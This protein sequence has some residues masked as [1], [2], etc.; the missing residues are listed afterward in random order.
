VVLSLQDVSPIRSEIESELLAIRARRRRQ[1]AEATYSDKLTEVKKI[2]ERL[3]CGTEPSGSSDPLVLPPLSVF[4]A[5]PSVRALKGSP[6]PNVLP[7][8][9]TSV[10]SDLK[11][12]LAMSLIRSDIHAW[13]VPAQKHLMTLLGYPNGW[14]SA[15]MRALPPVKRITARFF[16]RRCG[17]GKVGRGYQR[18]LCLD[19]K[20]VCSHVCVARGKSIG[21]EAP[22]E[23]EANTG[24]GNEQESGRKKK[25][26][27]KTLDWKIDLF[28]K[29]EKVSL[30]PIS[31][32]RC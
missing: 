29:D 17:E 20:G 27:V 28:E 5:L 14:Q 12:S 15:N 6:D 24:D 26:G 25:S 2:Y 30:F 1:K 16:C 8:E 10:T 13:L 11:S 31:Y 4:C 32:D 9:S 3:R 21:Q 23:G 22:P 7:P 19:L 18:E